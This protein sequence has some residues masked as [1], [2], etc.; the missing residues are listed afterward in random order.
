M[1]VYRALPSLTFRGLLRARDRLHAELAENVTLDELAHEAGL[2][3]FHFIRVFERLFGMTPHRYQV[4]LRLRRAKELLREPRASVTAVCFDTGFSSLGS[5][6][7]LFARRFGRSPS[8]YRR[9]FVTLAQV[10]GVYQR[11]FVPL[12]FLEHF[13]SDRNFGEAWPRAPR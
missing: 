4:E 2:S 8:A 10:P 11:I 13:A 6:S 9:E 5:F 3:R 7:A 12:C 1:D